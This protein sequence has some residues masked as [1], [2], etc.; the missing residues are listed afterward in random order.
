[1]QNKDQTVP[2]ALRIPITLMG[3]IRAIQR[4]AEE[5]TGYSVTASEVVR[6][7]IRDGIKR[8]KQAQARKRR[9]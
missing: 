7:L 6:R 2:M 8:D 1:M 5:T 4:R 9:A 3:E